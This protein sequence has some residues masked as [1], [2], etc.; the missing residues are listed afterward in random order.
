MTLCAVCFRMKKW[1]TVKGWPHD[2]I[3]IAFDQGIQS[4]QTLPWV[5]HVTFLVVPKRIKCPKEAMHVEFLWWEWP[6]PQCR[7]LINGSEPCGGRVLIPTQAGCKESG[8][9][10]DRRAT[11]S[12]SSHTCHPNEMKCQCT[13]QC[14]GARGAREKVFLQYKPIGIDP[15]AQILK[16]M[17]WSVCLY[18]TN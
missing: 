10:A 5:S 13:Q 17:T 11:P 6:K 18:L 8:I 2:S 15:K 7:A 9:E 4:L 16:R 1:G 3:R 14:Q 12:P